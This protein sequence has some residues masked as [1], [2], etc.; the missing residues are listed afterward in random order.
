MAEKLTRL[1]YEIAI[2]LHLLSKI[3]IDRP[4]VRKLLDTPSHPRLPLLSPVSNSVKIRWVDSEWVMRAARWT[5]P[6]LYAFSLS[7]CSNN[8]ISSTSPATRTQSTSYFFHLCLATMETVTW[9][10][11]QW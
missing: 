7:M 2:Q 4:P 10:P 8:R 6:S 3:P 9:K 1:T 5:R 11:T